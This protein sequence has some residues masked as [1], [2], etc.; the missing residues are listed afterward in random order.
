[1]RVKTTAWNIK[2]Y[3]KT[4]EQRAL[5]LE[6]AIEEAKK[7]GDVKF[8]AIAFSDVAK[9]I[10]SESISA[11]AIMEKEK[12]SRNRAISLRALLEVKADMAFFKEKGQHFLECV[13]AGDLQKRPELGVI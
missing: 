6:A 3:L 5:Y 8:L 12:C 13:K 9:A 2:D 10:G 7:D 4:P 1:M 11:K